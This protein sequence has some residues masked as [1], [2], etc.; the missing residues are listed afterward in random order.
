MWPKFDKLKDKI[1]IVAP[2]NG[3]T[4]KGLIESTTDKLNALGYIVDLP[5]NIFDEETI[6]HSNNDDYRFKHLLKLINS[7][8]VKVIWCF[9]GGYGSAKLID[10][11]SKIPT[12]LIE[13]IFIGFSD[14]T[15]LLLFFN[16]KWGWH[17]IHG[18]TIAQISMPNKINFQNIDKVLRLIEERKAPNAIILNKLN[19]IKITDSI[20]GQL[21]VG[22]LA[23]IQTSIGTNW[24]IDA[25]NKIV[26]LEDVNEE[27]YRIERMLFHLKQA[28]IFDNAKAIIF[29]ELI[30]SNE[31]NES[32]LVYYALNNFMQT[33]GVP[34][35]KTNM[36]GHGYNNMPIVEGIQ[37]YITPTNNR[38]DFYYLLNE[39]V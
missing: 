6:F 26:I 37:G 35:F 9:A 39:V 14:I 8:E 12:P 4:I 33:I 17:T 34:V 15:A 1:Y 28:R 29:G 13:K 11:L 10:D 25:E 7:P 19:D 3:K 23:I 18:S 5:D 24:Q 21:V 36:I 22:N 32:N 20:V 31:S 16:Q 30:N 27:G 2:A 38:F